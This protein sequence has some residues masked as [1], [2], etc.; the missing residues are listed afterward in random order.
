MQSNER[1]QLPPGVYLVG[2]GPG[3]PDLITVKGLRYLSLADVVVYD[4]LVSPRLL[5]RARPNSKRIFVGP[6]H[7]PAH[8]AQTELNRLL[9]HYYKH[10]LAVVR[11][12]GGDPLVFSRGGEE[13]A[14][15][16]AA[17]VPFEVVPGVSAAMAA[18]AVAGI[19][20]TDRRASSLV[21]LVTG[22]ECDTTGGGVDWRV[23]AQL[24]GTIAVFMGVRNLRAITRQLLA[25]GRSA[26]EPV[27]IIM[28][29]TTPGERVILGTL[30]TITDQAAAAGVASPAIILIGQVV[31]LR[32]LSTVQRENTVKQ[33][34]V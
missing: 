11:L 20:L 30:A 31:H 3:D 33:E 9:V 27:A 6:R 17:G 25:A 10:G 28:A 18:G 26:S 21:T 24:D 22:H 8:L 32:Q 13:M 16:A 15:L 29:A 23:L 12:K 34:H 4:D 7:T 5:D 19:P 1:M 2:A 14:A